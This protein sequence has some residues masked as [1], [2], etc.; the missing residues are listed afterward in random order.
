MGYAARG[1]ITI[2]KCDDKLSLYFQFRAFKNIIAKK[3][4]NDMKKI[5]HVTSELEVF[6]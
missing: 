5:T 6:Q 3:Q 2:K 1:Q 4:I